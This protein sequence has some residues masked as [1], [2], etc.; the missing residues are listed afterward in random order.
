MSDIAELEL[1]IK[2]EQQRGDELDKQMTNE[3]RLLEEGED[4]KWKIITRMLQQQLAELQEQNMLKEQQLMEIQK[5][6]VY[7]LEEV[8]E[9]EEKCAASVHFSF[10]Y[11]IFWYLQVCL[12]IAMWYLYTYVTLVLCHLLFLM[13]LI[14]KDA[15]IYRYWLYTKQCKYEN[16]CNLF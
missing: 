14:E 15:N 7:T 16:C 10:L 4:K 1:L 2:K 8:S 12:L 9:L 13:F 3:Q 6:K 11:C 5:W